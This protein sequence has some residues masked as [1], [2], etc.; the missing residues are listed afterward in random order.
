MGRRVAMWTLVDQWRSE[1]ML[2]ED[3]DLGSDY[4]G[5]NGNGEKRACLR[6]AEQSRRRRLMTAGMCNLGR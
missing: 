5:G 3:D 1:C 4:G 2:Q 6:D